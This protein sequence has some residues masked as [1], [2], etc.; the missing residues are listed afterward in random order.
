MTRKRLFLYRSKPGD[1]GKLALRAGG[2]VSSENSNRKE[3]RWGSAKTA[4]NAVKKAWT[5]QQRI[6]T[7]MTPPPLAPRMAIVTRRIPTASVGAER[8]DSNLPNNTEVRLEDASAES[9]S[10]PPGGK[11]LSSLVAQQPTKQGS[12]TAKEKEF[13]ASGQRWRVELGGQGPPEP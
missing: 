6:T 11:L 10:P 12:G 4:K 5:T 13:P 2:E 3:R 7:S 8:G 9:W 1:W